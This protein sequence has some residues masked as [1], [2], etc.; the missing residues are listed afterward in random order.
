MNKFNLSFI[1]HRRNELD[2]SMKK[3]ADELGFKNA[4]TYLKYERGDYS[5]KA[6]Q[7]P[8]LSQILQCKITDFFNQNVAKIAK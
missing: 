3:M 2:I 1:E 5:F 8:A 6:K 4:S 7:L